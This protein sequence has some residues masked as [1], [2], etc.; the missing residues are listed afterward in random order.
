MERGEGMVQW[1]GSGYLKG[2][3]V[4]GLGGFAV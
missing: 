1:S 3:W 4:V 2:V